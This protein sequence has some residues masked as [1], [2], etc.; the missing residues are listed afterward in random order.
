MCPPLVDYETEQE[1]R[2]HYEREYCK[3]P[4]TTPNG[5]RIYFSKEKFDHIFF[6]SVQSKDDTFSIDRSQRIDWIK[7][8]LTSNDSILYQ[9]YD[10]ETKTHYPDRRVALRYENFVVVVQLSLN[11][12]DVL[13]GNIVT[14]FKADNSIDEIKSSPLWNENDCR[15]LLN[16]KKE[17]KSNKK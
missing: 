3:T 9:G 6:E 17:A 1:Y 14:C 15:N 11:K 4:I 2:E 13:K 16:L 5:I 7:H 12:K 8:T 10:Q